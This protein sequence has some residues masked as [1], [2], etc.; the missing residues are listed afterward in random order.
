MIGRYALP[1]DD[2]CYRIGPTV[3]ASA[4][5]PAYLAANLVDPNPAKPAKL[6]AN[7]GNWVLDFGTPVT[8]VGA[9]LFYHNL[10]NGLA[11][12]LEANSANSWGSPA[13]SIEITIPGKTEDNYPVSPWIEF[14]DDGAQTYQYWRL[15][16]GNGSPDNE[17]PISVGRL[18]L[19]SAIRDLTNDVRWGVVEE[20]DHKIIENPTELGVLTIYELGG[21]QRRFSGELA[22]QDTTGVAQAFVALIRSARGRALNWL[23]IPDAAVNDAWV[24]RVE[25]SRWSRTRETIDHNIFPFR[26]QEEARGLDWP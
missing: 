24:V 17:N 20:E 9:A 3:T 25:E 4:E 11:V 12:T 15:V 5:D 8:I 22:L 1:L 19:L 14:V 16:C 21:K 23:L 13:F 18:M 7:S 2:Q 6:T 10:D 26:V